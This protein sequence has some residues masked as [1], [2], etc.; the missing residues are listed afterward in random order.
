MERVADSRIVD[1]SRSNME[2]ASNK[3]EKLNEL[4]SLE[5]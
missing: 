3:S 4:R 5:R 1:A 2:V